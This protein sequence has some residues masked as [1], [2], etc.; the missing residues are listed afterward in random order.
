MAG[1]DFKPGA[2]R[3]QEHAADIARNSRAGLWLFLVYVLLYGG[4]MG[5]SAFAPKYMSEVRILGANLAIV[6]GFGLIQSALILALVYT[7]ICRAPS[8]PSESSS[9]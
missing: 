1:L 6:Y 8:A 5:L 9:I 7:W 3:E 4:F 2:A